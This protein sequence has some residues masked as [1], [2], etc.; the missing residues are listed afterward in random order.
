MT[1][2]QPISISAPRL[3]ARR[4]RVQAAETG[5]SILKALGTLGGRASLTLLASHIGESPAKV[6]RYLVS[7][8]EGGLVAQDST[9]QQYYLGLEA[10][11]LGLAAMR[12]ADPIRMAEESLIRLRE[13]LGITCFIAVMGNK[14]PTIVRFEE[15]SLP[16]TVNVRVGSV[17]SL[18]WSATGRT[19]LS[20]SEDRHI[21]NLAYEELRIATPEQRALLAAERPVETLRLTL[22]ASGCI[23]VRD[24]NL[25]GISA[26]SAPLQDYTGRACA[27]LTALGATGGFDAAPNGPVGQ[28][29]Q[30]EARLVSKLLGYVGDL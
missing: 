20:T 11:L 1:T 29:V 12:Q 27:V 2:E 24:T 5:V 23:S 19:F 6:H 21:T 9:T 10:L 13:E 22:L 4:Q 16:V 3:R 28:A 14:G 30:R 15:P 26:V 8:L 25:L 17:L 7:L 18:L